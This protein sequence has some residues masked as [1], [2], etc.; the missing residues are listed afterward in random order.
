MNREQKNKENEGRKQALRFAGF[1]VV[2]CILFF[3]LQ[4]V[5]TPDYDAFTETGEPIMEGA[6]FYSRLTIHDLYTSED[7]IDMLFLGSSHT[8]WQYDPSIIDS[9]LGVHSFNAG[10]SA[11]QLDTSYALLVEAGKKNSIDTVFLELC[12]S[13]KGIVYSEREDLSPVYVVS[14]YMHFGLNK[15]KYL[16]N[17]SQSAFYVNSF[18]PLL[19]N[20]DNYLDRGYVKN[21]FLRTTGKDFSHYS[22]PEVSS[23]TKQWYVER[24]FLANNNA[25]ENEDWKTSERLSMI[26]EEM[27]SSEE[28]KA[29]SKIADYCK[30]HSIR[31]ILISTPLTDFNNAQPGNYDI[32]REQIASFAKEND[33]EFYDFNLCRPEY[34]TGE[35]SKYFD[36]SHMNYIGAEEYSDLVGRFFSGEIAEK[37]LFYDSYEDKLKEMGNRVFGLAI[38][39]DTG[40]DEK[41]VHL[42]PVASTEFPVYVNVKSISSDGTEKTIMEDHILDDVHFDTEESG[43]L[44]V[45][46]LGDSH[47]EVTNIIHIDY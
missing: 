36:P 8:Y 43:T 4:Y 39:V 28:L 31:L 47:A 34:L 44:V 22:T 6:R 32:G 41:T 9:Y 27:F 38:S 13:V 16:L 24:G 19:R 42:E 46:V 21:A 1:V 37:D 5:L 29:L 15:V 11:Q 12:P 33:L 30:K 10:T 20:K 35:S 14:D 3:S 17:A 7:N 18:F 25:V 2:F 40:E 45:E 23:D 26:K